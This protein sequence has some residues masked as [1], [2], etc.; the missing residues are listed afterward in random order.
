MHFHTRFLKGTRRFIS[1]NLWYHFNWYWSIYLHL[2]VFL[3]LHPSCFTS[4]SSSPFLLFFSFH[5]SFHSFSFN[6]S[7]IHTNCFFSFWRR[8]H[9]WRHLL[10]SHTETAH[11][12]ASRLSPMPLRREREGNNCISS[13]YRSRIWMNLIFLS[14][15]LHLFLYVYAEFWIM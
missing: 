5:H 7:S 10:S 11:I 1:F 2:I 12:S 4:S 6:S 14:S 13:W 15:F 3:F 8:R 9:A